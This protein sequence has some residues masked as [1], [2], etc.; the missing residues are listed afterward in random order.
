MRTF[1]FIVL[2]ALLISGCSGDKPAPT[3]APKVVEVPKPVPV[4]VSRDNERYL[5][6]RIKE[7]H[8]SL[9]I[10]K[11][12]KNSMNSVELIIPTSIP[13]YEEVKVGD[14]LLKSKGFRT[15]SLIFSGSFSDYEMVVVRKAEKL[16]DLKK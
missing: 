8:F 15:G 5:L 10:G 12:I 4:S 16:E 14:N 1:I 3:P 2:T 11:H 7:S 9:D 13:F 6:V